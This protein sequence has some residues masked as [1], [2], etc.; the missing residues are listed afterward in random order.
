MEGEKRIPLEIFDELAGVREISQTDKDKE[1]NIE[2]APKL[3]QIHQ[4]FLKENSLIF[5]SLI[6]KDFA[7]GLYEYIIFI[8]SFKQ[9]SEKTEEDNRTFIESLLKD[10]KYLGDIIKIIKLF[11][12]VF[13]TYQII[14]WNFFPKLY[15]EVSKKVR[16]VISSVTETFVNLK[17]EFLNFFQFDKKETSEDDNIAKLSFEQDINFGDLGLVIKESFPSILNTGLIDLNASSTVRDTILAIQRGEP[18]TKENLIVINTY[19]E[20]VDESSPYVKAQTAKN[21]YFSLLSNE[22]SKIDGNFAIGSPNAQTYDFSPIIDLN[23]ISVAELQYSTQTLFRHPRRGLPMLKVWY[24]MLQF[25]ND[26]LKNLANL[27]LYKN[28]V[29][30]LEEVNKEI[31]DK[32]KPDLELLEKEAADEK[33]EE[34]AYLR[35]PRLPFS[36]DSI[37]YVK[38]MNFNFLNE[39]QKTINARQAELNA[40]TRKCMLWSEILGLFTLKL[41]KQ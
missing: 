18:I 29:D 39:G 25:V 12:P 7:K 41:N 28:E 36:A 2:L 24:Q 15:Q 3:T 32:S 8:Q 23:D 33:Y 4:A 37:N 1:E 26:G 17:D 22:S 27:A 19:I 38:K 31:L 6:R 14:I 35:T 16:N 21:L 5:S 30:T 20:S 11:F 34:F 9:L 13:L 40:Q 10:S